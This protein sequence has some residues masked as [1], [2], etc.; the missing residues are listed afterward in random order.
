MGGGL[1]ARGNLGLLPARKRPRRGAVV[2]EDV[3]RPAVIPDFR[4]DS[5]A[6]VAYL[7]GYESQD[8]YHTFC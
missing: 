6:G 5:D 4:L 3:G 8:I 2:R 1:I 7:M